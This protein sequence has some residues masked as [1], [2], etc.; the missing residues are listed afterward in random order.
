MFLYTELVRLDPCSRKVAACATAFVGDGGTVNGTDADN[1][2]VDLDVLKNIHMRGYVE[3][4]KKGVSTIMVSFSSWNGVK[5]HANKFL[6]TD[7]L[8]GQMGFKVHSFNIFMLIFKI[9]VL[10]DVLIWV[11]FFRASLSPTGSASTVSKMVGVSLTPKARVT[12]TPLSSHSMPALT[13]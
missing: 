6:L 12:S 4:I 11:L 7:V 5:M 2:V 8:K 1:T 10:S 3:A 9:S 13:W